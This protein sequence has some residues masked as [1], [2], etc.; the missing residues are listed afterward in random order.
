MMKEHLLN[1][2]RGCTCLLM[3]LLCTSALFA[4]D[5]TIQGIV[6]DGESGETL[7]GVNVL[8]R[9]SSIGTVTDV[10][11]TYNLAVPTGD[12]TLV[13]SS[14]GYTS[15]EM[16]VGNQSTVDMTLLPDI[17]SLTEV[18]VVGYGTQE[19]KD[20]TGA[21]STVTSKEI[22]ELPI[23]SP[24]QALQGRT[25]GVDVVSNGNR[26]GAGVSVRIRG[27]RSFSAGNDPLYVLDGIPLAGDNSDINPMDIASIEVL[28][29]ASATA[30]YG[31]RGANGVVLITTK[32]GS[33]GKTT[34]NYDGYY[35]VSSA[36]NTVDVMNGPQFAAYKRESRRTVGLWDPATPEQSDQAIF[37]PVERESIAQGRTTDYQNLILR[38]GHRQ[39]HQIGIYGGSENTQFGVSGNYFNDEGIVPGQDFTRFTL[40]L[41]VDNQVSDRLKLGGSILGAFSIRNEGSNAIG[42]ALAENPLGVPYDSLGNLIF[43]PTSDGLRTNPLAEI[44]PG[45]VIGENRRTRFF[46]SLYGEYKF[47]EGFTYRL[48]F[49][50]DLQMRR[51][52]EFLG[53]QTNARR[54]GDPTGVRQDWNEFAYTLENI[55]NYQKTLGDIHSL[56][57]TAL[58]SIQNSRSEYSYMS[59]LGIPVESMSFYNLGDA[60]VI[61]GVDTNLT[62]WTINS[63]MGRIN[64][65]LLDKY[66]IT[67]TG[68]SDGSSRFAEGKKYGFFPSIALGWRIKE[69]AFLQNASWLTDLKLR[70]SYGLTGNT[71]IDPYQTQGQIGRTTYAF[72][73]NAGFGYRPL[74]LPNPNLKWETT[75][76]VNFGV[77]FSFINGRISGS[78]EVYQQNTRD[79]LMPRQLPI[80]SGFNGVLENVGATRNS[81]V[82]AMLSTVNVSTNGGFEWTTDLNFYANKEE[83][84]ELYGGKEDDIGNNW[85]IGQPLTVYYD[86]QKIGIWQSS[87]VDEATKYQRVPGEIR[88]KDQLTVDSNGDGRPDQTDGAINADDRIILGSDIPKWSGG[89]TNRFRYKGIDLSVF[90]FTRQGS[91]LRSLLHT[92]NNTLAGR[93]NNLNVDYWTPE[94]PTNAYPRPNK[95]QEFP[96]YNSSVSLF[97]ASFIKIRNI[98]LGY[99][100]PESLTSKW[101]IQQLRIYASAQQPFIF[102]PYISKYNG[103]D[104]EIARQP[105]GDN[106][107]QNAELGADTPASKIFL[108]GLNVKF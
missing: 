9:G 39:S 97:D 55:F 84:V 99:T 54:G 47:F 5:R 65:G 16:A 24:E 89:M 34:I 72:G 88:I 57:I 51:R 44:V 40:R 14:V 92:S 19:K 95:D 100:L 21:I 106:R 85:F 105:N 87:E 61:Q 36:L 41:A 8:V 103:V 13:F 101:G 11:G 60:N 71:G 77:D 28:R 67:L 10:N 104:P 37:E 81:G 48:N 35:G 91:M 12:Q 45:A 20:V 7:P 76:S 52:G 93:Y 3:L 32:R 80:T 62:E 83:I 30:I 64:Y 53:S 27:R 42:G 22:S 26:P 33:D 108:F 6:T 4:Q 86:Y 49:G 15:E 25:P 107:E 43:L 66:L 29:D 46:S 90:I 23:T 63:F 96:V 1:K 94:N 70:A 50:P 75:A 82:E 56:N 31:S 2:A 98:N 69:E 18:V 17:Q 78:A 102:A 74:F 59:V 68:R 38:K 58:H 79:L 73:S